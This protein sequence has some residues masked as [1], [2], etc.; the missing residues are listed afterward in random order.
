MYLIF[1]G[2]YMLWRSY[3]SLV[4]YDPDIN[5]TKLVNKFF[6]SLLVCSE[7]FSPEFIV[8]LWDYGTPQWRKD[9]NP[10]YKADREID[11]TIIDLINPS[12]SDINSKLLELGIFSFGQS[13][14][15]ADDIAY[16]MSKIY[17]NGILVSDDKDWFLSIS[18][19]WSVWRPISSELV[20]Y[21]RM[22]Q[23]MNTSINPIGK[24]L[25]YKAIIGDGSDNISGIPNV[26]HVSAIKYSEHLNENKEITDTGVRA[27]AI[28]NNL[29]KIASNRKLMD[30]SWIMKDQ[31]IC[32]YVSD[33]IIFIKPPKISD[34]ELLS[35]IPSMSSS[36]SRWKLVF[37]KLKKWNHYYDKNN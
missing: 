32:K 23:D 12:R 36:Y 6:S 16:W 1:D 2:S 30:L 4:S 10:E 18:E 13:G 7:Q 17:S 22:C 14:Y 21:E 27:V 25:W 19:S 5:T 37:S 24:Y 8:V 3:Y 28:S 34:I 26:G 35:I 33:G 31:D 15:E 20:T 11:D 29:E 9:E